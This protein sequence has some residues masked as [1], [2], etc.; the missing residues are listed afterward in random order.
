MG[1]PLQRVPILPLLA[2][3]VKFFFSTLTAPV[4]SGEPTLSHNSRS[5]ST[6]I[7]RI[8]LFFGPS[9][10][11]NRFRHRFPTLLNRSQCGFA[12]EREAR[13]YRACGLVRGPVFP[14]PM[15]QCSIQQAPL[16]TPSATGASS[17]SCPTAAGLTAARRYE[18]TL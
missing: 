6:T 5:V 18:R 2:T 4:A 12:V 7:L 14:S 13:A 3:I 9:L 15:P 1:S 16:T 10:I 17:R 11:D 8:L